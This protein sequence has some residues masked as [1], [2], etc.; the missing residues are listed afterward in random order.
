MP[1]KYNDQIQ[2]KFT[3]LIPTHNRPLFL[4]RLLS[5]LNH[6]TSPYP[7]VLADS[8]DNKY[9][10]DIKKLSREYNKLKIDHQCYSSNIH[11]TQKL[12]HSLQKISSNY[13]VICADDDFINPDNIE[14]CTQFLDQ[15]PD[16]S[17]AHGNAI[18]FRK[19]SKNNIGF[20]Y[21]VGIY[22]QCDIDD[23]DPST[24]LDKHL[25]S[26]MPTF[27]SVQR[28]DDLQSSLELAYSNS[29]DYRFSEVLQSCLAIIKGK[30]KR[31]NTLHSVREGHIDN[32]S[33]HMPNW[34]DILISESYSQRYIKF[35]HTLATTLMNK[36]NNDFEFCEKIVQKSWLNYLENI[37]HNRRLEI[38]YNHKDYIKMID[39]LTAVL[40]HVP[41]NQ[42]FSLLSM[43]LP[44]TLHKAHRIKREIQQAEKQK[45]LS[46]EKNTLTKDKHSFSL[47]SEIFE[48]VDKYPT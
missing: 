25:S 45:N 30:A 17:I 19:D 7:I 6:K 12:I 2:N 11:F 39:S 14:P 21:N 26:Y 33:N 31:F 20:K 13:V 23:N 40:Q 22:P 42:R 29:E 41:R 44:S 32:A 10:H 8:S 37:F 38:S 15:N 47:I 9:H 28:K 48:I 3:F 4:R 27:Y 24:R 36:T 18:S 1:T 34:Q 46:F 43:G 5:Y 16:Y 35:Q